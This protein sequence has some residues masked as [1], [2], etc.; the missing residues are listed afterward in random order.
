MNVDASLHYDDY[1][2]VGSVVRDFEGAIFAAATWPISPSLKVNEVGAQAVYLG[3]KF[4][5]EC[6]FLDV[7]VDSDSA[8]VI[9]ALSTSKPV[10]N[11]FGL[12]ISNCLASLTSFKSVQSSHMK[13]DGNKV[14]HE[15]ANIALT[16]PNSCGWKVLQKLFVILHFWTCWVLI[17]KA[18]HLF[19]P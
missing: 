8:L 5:R 12:L 7:I 3:L 1:G 18:L 4:A 11:Y 6:Y 10:D 19:S 14:A 13:R 15:L 2:G 16:N 17:N 9:Q